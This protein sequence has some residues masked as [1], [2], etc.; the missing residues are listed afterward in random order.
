[1]PK[2]ITSK[3]LEELQKEAFKGLKDWVKYC[4][5]LNYYI[6]G[7]KQKTVPPG[8]PPPKPPGTP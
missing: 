2:Q 4:E 7:V 5:D 1:M 8:T 6:V 3:Q